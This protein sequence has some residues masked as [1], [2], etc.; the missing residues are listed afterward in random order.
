[1]PHCFDSNGN[2][3]ILE[4]PP[5]ASSGEGKV[6]KT[7]CKIKG[8]RQLA[9]LYH[10]N[11]RTPE[12]IAKLRLLTQNP[13]A[14]PNA[15]KGHISFA[16]PQSLLFDHQKNIVGFLMS[17]IPGK[18]LVTICSPKLR[19]KNKLSI[20]WLFLHTVALNIASIIE[21]IHQYRPYQYVLGD[22]KLEN[23]L[24]NN[25]A[26][27]SII[28][29]DSFQVSAPR[30][31]K[32]F[33]CLVGSEG[34]TPPELFGKD[35]KKEIQY[36]EQDYFRLGVV[37]YYLLFG[38]H[39]FQ[40]IWTG[41]G[42]PPDKN[43]L[44][45]QGFW[46]YAPQ[47]RRFIQVSKRTIPLTIL[48]PQLEQCFLQCFNDGHDNPS[49]RPKDEDWVK[50]L[51]AALGELEQCDQV[52]SHWYSRRYGD[53]YW[54][55][56]AR[57]LKIDIFPEIISFNLLERFL[58]KKDWKQADL[59]TKVLLLKLTKGQTKSWLNEQ[60]IQS[61][62]V[63][64]LEELDRLWRKASNDHFGFSIQ[65]QIYLQTGNQLDQYNSQNYQ[66]FGEQVGW[67]DKTTN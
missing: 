53:C 16:W 5:I 6:S 62:E 18:N 3:I 45:R 65:K 21:A 51:E 29:V 19:Q 1:M 34:F 4:D 40:G 22:I 67:W 48:H 31:R 27:P 55:E 50:A 54:C 11:T 49:Q 10:Q 42:E 58:N 37:I 30:S 24:V 46:P 63:K 57:D 8:K 20:D 7:N 28:D 26:L 60:S 12:R 15:G 14:D 59:E 41:Q 43:Q 47:N 17:E 23:I 35:F 25:Q 44:V 2:K 66:K 39:P 36:P 61:I 13:A 33:H 9:K 64:S 32:R 52:D 56:R 38:E